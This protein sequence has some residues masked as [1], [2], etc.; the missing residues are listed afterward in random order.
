MFSIRTPQ[1]DPLDRGPRGIQV[2]G[3]GKKCLKVGA[4][5]KKH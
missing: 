4:V 1:I 5:L 3:I 2:G